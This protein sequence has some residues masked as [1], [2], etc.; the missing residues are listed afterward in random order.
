[1]KIDWTTLFA[2]FIPWIGIGIKKLYKKI[3]HKLSFVPRGHLF[4]YSYP[5]PSI[6][7]GGTLLSSSNLIV[8]TITVNVTNIKT[9]EKREFHAEMELVGNLTNPQLHL[10]HNFSLISSIPKGLRLYLRENN[11]SS[12]IVR[13]ASLIRREWQEN[14]NFFREKAI[15][16]IQ[17]KGINEILKRKDALDVLAFEIFKTGNQRYKKAYQ[18]QKEAFFWKSGDYKFNFFINS[19]K[20]NTITNSYKVTIPEEFAEDSNYNSNAYIESI[21][22]GEQIFSNPDFIC[23]IEQ[24]S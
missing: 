5:S 16:R 1:M 21:C 24:I 13:E 4:V 19:N 14:Q 12:Q 8:N 2:S 6:V 3:T 11:I 9:N 15:E 17:K 23:P 7:I 22:F 18:L 10:F 20:G